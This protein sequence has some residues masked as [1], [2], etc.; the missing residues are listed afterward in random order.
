M[1][2]VLHVTPYLTPE[3][4]GPPVVVER[5][6]DHAA[7]AG[8]AAGILTTAELTG[9]HGAALRRA[10]PEA[11][12]LPSQRAA[13]T[14]RG[15]VARAV[16]GADILHLHTLWSPLCAMAA[17]AARAARMPYVLSPHGMLDPWSMRQKAA[18]KRLYWRLVEGRMARGAARIVY[19]T[20]AERDL[21]VR[22][23]GA[24]GESAV[25]PLG[26]DAP[27]G[28]RDA[29]ADAFAKAHPDLA[30]TP[31]IVFLGRLHPKK[32]PEAMVAALPALR[33]E[34]PEATLAFVG[35]G[36][37]EAAL[38]QQAQALGVADAVAVLGQ[39][40]GAAKWQALAAADL[41]V[42]PS[43]QE[44]FAI[45]VAEALRIGLPVL[46]TRSVNIWQEVTEAGAG[47][48]LDEADL[49]ASIATEAAR[50][51]RDPARRE[52]MGKRAEALAA[53][54]FTW[55]E[56]TRRTCALYDDILARPA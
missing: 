24:I 30:G 44:N 40:T 45:A 2:R 34:V 26:A 8:W 12:V 47:V 48:A 19:T 54:A 3:A 51:L 23:V 13:L 46:L 56:C 33:A 15:A 21:A 52:A 11:T 6:A 20:A 25:I 14:Q 38:R 10:R 42:L 50:L 5:L 7:E 18:K 37:A 31:L 27:P 29:L 55:P 32:R 36:E 1:R 39:R 49:P 53:R 16:A 9:D 43:R 22:S 28:P 41:F 4:G 17:R 35:T